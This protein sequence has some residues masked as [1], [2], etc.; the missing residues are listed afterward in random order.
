LSTY[1]NYE[2][3]V[4]IDDKAL[5][6]PPTNYTFTLQDSI[7]TLYPTASFYFDD[8]GGLFNEF[9]TF[10]NGTKMEITLGLPDDF[11]VCPYIIIKNSIPDQASTNGFGGVTNVSLVHEYMYE[12]SKKSRAFKDEITNIIKRIV[13]YSFKKMT[14]ETTVNKGI[15]YQPFIYDTEFIINNMLPF[16]YSSTAKNTPYY[17]FINSNNEFNFVSY[18]HMFNNSN[19]MELKLVPSAITQSVGLDSVYSVF[20]IQSSISDIRS[21]LNT[22]QYSFD[23]NN[24]LKIIETEISDYRGN[25][26]K[27]PIRADLDNKTSINELYSNDCNDENI[28]NNNKGL[29]LDYMRNIFTLDKVILVCN[30]NVKIVS[31]TKIKLGVPIATDNQKMESSLRY[32]GEYIV[33]R[34]YHSWTSFGANSIIIASRNNITV[35]STYLNSGVLL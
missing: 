32:S 1:S 8:V 5:D 2:I 9:L 25:N 6:Y 22:T 31:G 30:L 29:T 26:N 33:E 3:A 24:A 11:I 34:S 35:P 23:K 12:Q 20:P 16:A 19:I 15:W 17:C 13:K 7:H 10:I 21:F 18:Q 4:K 27:I 14:L 28:E